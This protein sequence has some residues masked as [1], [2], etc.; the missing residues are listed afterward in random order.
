[1]T[2]RLVLF[3]LPLILQGCQSTSEME[4]IAPSAG[5]AV[6]TNIVAH[7][8]DPWPRES[9][10]HAIAFD[11]RYIIQNNTRQPEAPPAR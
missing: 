11:A 1:M 5:N 7:V 2:K 6:R 4:G 3:L 10:S 9:S 8:I